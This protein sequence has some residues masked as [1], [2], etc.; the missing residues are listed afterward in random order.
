MMDR[1]LKYSPLFG[2]LQKKFTL[3]KFRQKKK[4]SLN[5][6][7]R[8]PFSKKLSMKKK[9]IQKINGLKNLRIIGTQ[10]RKMLY[11]S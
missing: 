5:V 4:Q 9:F 1:L 2:G 8:F 10:V 11:L 6:K 3:K 7:K